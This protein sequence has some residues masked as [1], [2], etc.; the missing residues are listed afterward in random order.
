MQ[1][2]DFHKLKTLKVAIAN[3]VAEITFCR[4]RKLNS[5]NTLFWVELPSVLEAIDREAAARVAIICANGEHFTAG[6]DLA[7]FEHMLSRFD[8]E[9]A[10]FF[11]C[12]TSSRLFG[13]TISLLDNIIDFYY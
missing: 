10:S 4:P 8:G 5:M 13:Q 3:S 2:T 1:I 7:V 9:P 12:A 11:L 6:M